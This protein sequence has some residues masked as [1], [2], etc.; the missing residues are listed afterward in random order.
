MSSSCIAYPLWAFSVEGR[1]AYAQDEQDFSTY[2][3]C[4]ILGQ[5]AVSVL[6]ME[7]RNLAETIQGPEKQQ[8]LVTCDNVQRLSKELADLKA[9]GMV[10][11]VLDYS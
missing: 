7:G 1:N 4:F 5:R 10:R 8:L 11:S 3:F 9:R 6:V 2:H